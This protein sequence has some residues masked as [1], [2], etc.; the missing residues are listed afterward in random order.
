MRVRSQFLQRSLDPRFLL[1]SQFGVGAFEVFG[2]EEFQMAT[3]GL[4][5][6]G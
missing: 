3:I 2:T 5:Y 1:G 6:S 4:R